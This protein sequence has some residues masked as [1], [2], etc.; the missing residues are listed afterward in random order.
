MYWYTG[1]DVKQ[2]DIVAAIDYH[3]RKYPS[4]TACVV[5]VH[6]SQIGTLHSEMGIPVR[7]DKRVIKGNIFV[8]VA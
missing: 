8:A 1:K 7:P 6:P 5:Y 4:D 2:S 3:R